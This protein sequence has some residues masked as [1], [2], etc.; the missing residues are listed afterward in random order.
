MATRVIDCDVHQRLKSPKDLYPYLSDAVQRDID[1]WG[2]RLPANG[3]RNGGD[4]AYRHDAW[5]SDGSMVG[6]DL[7]LMREQLLDAYDIEYAVLLGQEIRLVNTMPEAEYAATLARAYNDWLVECWLEKDPRLCGAIIVATQ[8]PAEAA[9]E[10]HRAA[11][12][13]PRLVEVMVSNGANIPYGQRYYDPIFEACQELG[14]P[15]AI[16]TG[17]EDH[18]A[19]SGTLVGR[20]SYYI[21]ARQL[22]PHGYQAHLSSMIFEGFFE[23]FPQID[24]VF[25]E[26]GYVWLP[27]YLWRL[28]SDWYALRDE[29][30]WVQ[31]PPSEYVFE[32]CKFT[33]QPMETAEKPSQIQTM[34]EWARAD[35][36]LM[37]ASDY[38]HWDFDS[39]TQSLPKMPP[40]M[41]D[42]VMA[43]NAR[44]LYRL[45]A[46]TATKS[47]K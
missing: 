5:P 20:P 4:R 28:D 24:V 44:E 3:Y 11:A 17:S 7:D 47:A 22:R 9:K 40:H 19:C 14:L 1:H 13:H 46:R 27:P 26:G 34:M 23:R 41:H 42:R 43:E 21:E 30:P 10:I 12:Q 18:G 25:I 35:Q 36:T 33:S 6:S 32:R 29:V 39:P 2:L 16:H 37:F 38:P 45:P 31:K 15:F 8:N